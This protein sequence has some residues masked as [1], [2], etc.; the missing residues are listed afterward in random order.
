MTEDS[1]S[2]KLCQ[3]FLETDVLEILCSFKENTG[4]LLLKSFLIPDITPSPQID[5]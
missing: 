3:K 4:S 2:S 1:S 5:K